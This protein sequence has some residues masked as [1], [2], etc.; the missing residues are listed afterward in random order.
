MEIDVNVYDKFLENGLGTCHVLAKKSN[1]YLLYLEENSEHFAICSKILK[2]TEN[3]SLQDV[4]Y[5]KCLSMALNL[6]N[7]EG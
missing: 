5:F 6:F 4:R 7:K 1:V 3:Y 2:T